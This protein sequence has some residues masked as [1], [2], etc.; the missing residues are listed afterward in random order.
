MRCVMSVSISTIKVHRRQRSSFPFIGRTPRLNVID[1]N[2]ETDICSH[3]LVCTP[4]PPP[5]SDSTQS[6]WLMGVTSDHTSL[7]DP[8]SKAFAI[9]ITTLCYHFRE[10]SADVVISERF[11]L[12]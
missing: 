11:E 1:V 10:S 7:W 9:T 6:L 4:P 12:E 8:W 2:G 5:S 3:C